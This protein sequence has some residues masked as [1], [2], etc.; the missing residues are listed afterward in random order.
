MH[1]DGRAVG[2]PAGQRG[3]QGGRVVDHQEVPRAQH[4]GQVG[5]AAV[6]DGTG[7]APADQHPDPV[8][9]FAARLRGCVGGE[10][11]R[12]VEVE[13]EVGVVGVVGVVG[14]CGHRPPRS[15]AATARG[16]PAGAAKW[17]AGAARSSAR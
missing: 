9:G 1:G 2:Q 5:E 16:C 14:E 13:A 7:G 12:D 6:L 4:L 11:G 3:R 10:F 8:P 17:S 15:A